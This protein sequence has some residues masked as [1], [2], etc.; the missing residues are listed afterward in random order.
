MAQ[1]FPRKSGKNYPTLRW[2]K[3]T[4]NRPRTNSTPS[5]AKSLSKERPEGEPKGSPSLT[6]LKLI[7]RESYANIPKRN[8]K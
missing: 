5:T 6:I 8:N 1:R 2:L 3:V 7:K 4:R